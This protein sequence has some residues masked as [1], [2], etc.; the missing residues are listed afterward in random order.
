KLQLY[1]HPSNWYT[2]C[3]KAE[4]YARGGLWVVFEIGDGGQQLPN[5]R[6]RYRPYRGMR[7]MAHTKSPER[8]GCQGYR[9]PMRRRDP[10]WPSRIASA[11]R[12]PR[13]FPAWPAHR[14]APTAPDPDKPGPWDYWD[15]ARVPSRMCL[16]PARNRVRNWRLGL[17][18][19]VVLQL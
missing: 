16:A 6:A 15:L 2:R 14:R 7:V 11:R 13:T 10:W 3:P 5:R 18:Q 17:P 1:P 4:M 8:I 12:Y 19:V 9:A